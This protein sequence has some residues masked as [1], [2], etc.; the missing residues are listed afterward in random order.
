MDF[1]VTHPRLYSRCTLSGYYGS[2]CVMGH[3]HSPKDNR[4]I[5]RSQ[6]NPLLGLPFRRTFCIS[7]RLSVHFSCLIH[8][9]I[10][11]HPSM[12]SYHCWLCSSGRLFALPSGTDSTYSVL[13]GAVRHTN[14]DQTSPSVYMEQKPCQY[15]A[16]S[17]ICLYI[18]VKVTFLWP[19]KC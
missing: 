8:V 7:H 5:T 3:S 11:D 2:L 12:S 19:D 16:N 18:S 10:S 17:W 6:S 13:P 9:Q 1:P 14:A 15:D 4:L